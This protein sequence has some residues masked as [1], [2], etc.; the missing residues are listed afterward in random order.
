MTARRLMALLL[1]LSAVATPAFGQSQ[2]INGTIE[3]TVRDAQ[4]GVLPGVNVLVLHIDTNTARTVLTNESGLFRAPLL[5]LGNYSVTFQL[6]GFARLERAGLTLTAGQAAVLNIT[7]TVGTQETLTVTTDTPPVD[8]A[9]TDVG[10]NL[11]E[12]EIK[13]LPNVSRNPYNFAL[14]EGGVTGNENN[15]FGVPRFAVNG[16]ML[17]INYQVDGNTNTQKDRAGLRLLPMSEVMIKEVQIVSSGYAPEFGQTTGMVYNA[18][19]PSGTNATRG[20]VAYRFRRKSFSAWPFGTTPV[21][22]AI[23]S[24]KPDNSL[25]IPTATIGGPIVRNKLFYYAGSERTYQDLTD[26]ITID[27][28]AAAQI[29]L[30]A[31]PVNVPAYR[32]A[33]FLIGKV[34]YT[35]TPKHRMNFRWN[36]FRNDNPFM[37][38]G[39]LTAAERSQDFKDVMYSAGSQLI[40]TL[41]D[42]RLNE[43]RVQYATRHTQRFNHD[44][45][46]DGVSVN[47]TGVANFGPATNDGEDFVQSISQVIDNLTWLRGNHSYKMG[48]DYQFIDDHRAVALPS[49]F[50]FPTIQAYLDAK[51]GVN[52]KSYTTFAQTIGQPAFDMT[53][54]MVSLFAQDDWK[55]TPDFKVI[56]GLRWDYN[57]YPSGIAGSP[58]Q[59]T[60][61]RDGD[62]ISPRF[63][64][65]WTLGADRKAVLRGSSGLMYDQ[66]LLA[67]IERAYA[68]TGF[69]ERFAVS[70]NAASPFAPTFPNTLA[71][72]P[73]NQA[74]TA[75]TV[76]AMDPTFVTARAWQNSLTY[77]RTLGESYSYSIGLRYARGWD[78]PVITDINLSGAEPV[79]FLEDG[80]RVYSA[81]QNAITRVDPRF[82][83]VRVVQSIG[84]STYTGMTAQLTKRWTG[85][86]QF[87]LNYTLG[88]GEDTAPLGGAVLAVQGD[89]NRSDPVDLERD[90]GPNQLDIRH[91]FNGS[92]VAVSSVTRFSPLVNRILT[93]NQAGVLLQ[94][95]SGQPDSVASNRD[96]NLDGFNNDRP[97]FVARNSM[98]VPPRWNVDL[99][100]SRFFK[101]GNV[102]KI[103]VQAEF[104]NLFNTE[105]IT[106]V[107]N[108]LEVDVDGYP[109]EPG[110][111]NRLPLSSIS[112]RGSDYVATNWAEQRKFQLGFKFYF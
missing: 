95:N 89:S 107:N 96:L 103:E 57:L 8:L 6:N 48:V 35:I 78:M 84:E 102:R 33:F 26:P 45:A 86:V 12:R 71:D 9:K 24:N 105:Q 17:R 79:R 39:G 60:F 81:A 69:P 13:N 31:Q 34:D 64:F 58:Y 20:E 109:V 37:G 25:D 49:Q 66:P 40:S 21:Q 14:L 47:V 72:I 44:A 93:D 43:L 38:A 19:T 67:I 41:G 94:F 53:N 97:L 87:N 101:L 16:Q 83:R 36:T 75:A 74:L 110:T 76:E 3:G 106:A 4:G 63:G 46:V 30:A 104:K 27:P 56:Y 29:G 85:G 32:S 54:S 62:N 77:E 59:E 28:A 52:L 1:L 10:R 51:S 98:N 88:K 108:T 55:V 61:N 111:L 65:A 11:T 2:A 73:P 90:K 80:R 7:L 22:R 18:V 112:L 50:T 15:E 42:N 70:L 99:R 5:P 23:P 92:I 91:T 82:N 68:N 100:Y